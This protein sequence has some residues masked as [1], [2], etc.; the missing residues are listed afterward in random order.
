MERF[1]DIEVE[2]ERFERS[3]KLIFGDGL[4]PILKSSERLKWFLSCVWLN[5]C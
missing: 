1:E 4:A 3:D 2:E 5:F